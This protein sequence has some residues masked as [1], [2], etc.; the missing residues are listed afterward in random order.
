MRSNSTASLGDGWCSVHF[1]FIFLLWV[2]GVACL[3][4]PGAAL[5]QDQP[6]TTV[7]EAPKEQTDSR[8]TA[9]DRLIYIPYEKLSEVVE[10]LKSKVVISY[11]F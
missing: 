3:S 6:G 4:V 7:G 11:D 9:V 8:P 2:L 1:R 5:A 10:R